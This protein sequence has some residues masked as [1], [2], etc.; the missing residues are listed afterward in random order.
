MTIDSSIAG[1]RIYCIL[2]IIQTLLFLWLFII[3]YCF[4]SYTLPH[5]LTITKNQ[6]P[7][8]IR[9]PTRNLTPTHGSA[10]TPFYTYSYVYYSLYNYSYFS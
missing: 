4:N 3:Y 2:S 1:G 6:L 10:S 7:I 9:T 5:A 8:I